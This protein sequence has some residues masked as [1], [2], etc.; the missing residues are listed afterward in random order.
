MNKTNS[1]SNTSICHTCINDI[2]H[3]SS[4]MIKKSHLHNGCQIID[5]CDGFSSKQDMPIQLTVNDLQTISTQMKADHIGEF[6][7]ELK[8][9]CTACY[10]NEP[11]VDC[12]VC[13]GEVTYYQNHV[14]DWTSMKDIYQ[15]M[16]ITKL[17][18]L[19]GQDNDEHL[20]QIKIQFLDHEAVQERDCEQHF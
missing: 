14:I 2:G 12:E 7:L 19:T 20:Q 6:H 1:L 15:Q 8:H 13:A 10:Y 4:V 3:C 18:E 17:K 9:T 11:E 16:L 5:D